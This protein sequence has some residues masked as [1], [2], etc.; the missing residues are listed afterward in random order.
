MLEC[1]VLGD[2]IAVGVGA[3][4]PHCTTVAQVGITSNQ[5]V[6]TFRTSPRSRSVLISLGSNDSDNFALIYGSLRTLRS[7]FDSHTRVCWLLSSNNV[8]A[9]SAAARVAQEHGDCT[10]QVR[11]HVSSDR[12]HPT[13]AGYSRIAAEWRN[14]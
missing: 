2:S 8:R 7:R 5:Y 6:H 11:P 14:K 10:I 12:V 9:Q 13:A 4:L 3:Q 1:V